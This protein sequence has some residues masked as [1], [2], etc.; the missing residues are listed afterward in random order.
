MDLFEK[1]LK[2]AEAQTKRFPNGDQLFKIISR[3][4]E[5]SGEVA[6]E[7]NHYERSGISTERNN[8]DGKQELVHET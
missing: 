2:V 5:E 7:L 1:V 6:W 8:K 3:I 4:L